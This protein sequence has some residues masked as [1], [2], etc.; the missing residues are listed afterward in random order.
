VADLIQSLR[1]P[2]ESFEFRLRVHQ[3]FDVA[4]TASEAVAAFER[5]CTHDGVHWKLEEE[6][7]EGLRARVHEAPGVFGWVQVRKSLHDPMV[8]VNT[9]S[10]S[11]LLF[12]RAQAE[13]CA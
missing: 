4:D 10:V 2:K 3:G 5:E 6:N 12:P 7:Y 13:I 8:I 1:E 11:S 9:E